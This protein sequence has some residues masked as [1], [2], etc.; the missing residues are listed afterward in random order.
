MENMEKMKI[1]QS[2]SMPLCEE[3]HIGT[4]AGGSKNDDYCVYCFKD[5]EFTSNKTLE[6]T[7]AESVNWAEEAGMTKEAM[8]AHAQSV[9]PTLK[10]WAK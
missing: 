7:I 3:K 9:L 2:C 8:L 10:R 1:C 4:N 5:G 6:E